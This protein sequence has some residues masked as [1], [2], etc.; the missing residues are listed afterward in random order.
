MGHESGTSREA[1]ILAGIQQ[2]LAQGVSGFSMRRVAAACGLSCA[3]P[4]KHFSGKEQFIYEILQY[5]R[6][7]WVQREQAILDVCQG[8]TRAQLIEISLGYVRFMLDNPH[9]RSILMMSETG[10]L[11][12]PGHPVR[13]ELSDTSREL[14]ERYCQ[15]VGMAP[16]VQRRKTF[17]VR[18]LIFGAA[19]MMDSGELPD[20][21]ETAAIIRA[22]IEREFDL[23]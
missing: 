5:I 1:L 21:E 7:R 18:S 4:Y 16:Q 15:E 8:D 6:G 22:A 2:L 3:A 19:L 17:V 11:S 10:G 23:A 14:I 13:T 12:L 20:D 9:F